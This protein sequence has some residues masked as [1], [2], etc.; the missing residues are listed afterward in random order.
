MW[1]EGAVT[2]R[3]CQSGLRS[4]VL[5]ISRWMTLHGRSNDRVHFLWGQYQRLTDVVPGPAAALPGDLLEM[6]ILRPTESKLRWDP[7]TCP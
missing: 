6:Q 2:D 1:G 5:E 7:A 4:L 3:T